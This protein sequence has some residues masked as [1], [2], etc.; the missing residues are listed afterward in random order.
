[1]KVEIL[2][3]GGATGTPS[4]EWGWGRCDPDEPRNRRLRPS[5]LIDGAG[6][7]ILVDTGPD[8]RE[9]LLRSGIQTVD[10]I[11]YTHAHAD[12]LHGI[13]DLRSVNRF[14][15]KALPAYADEETLASIR[16]RFSYVFDPLVDGAT[17]YYK[18]T[19]IPNTL[20][21]GDVV[22][23]GALRM[24]TFAQDH[25][26]ATTMGLRCGPVAYSTD[27]VELTEPAFEVLRGVDTWIVDAFQEPPH[28]THAHVGKVLEW[29]ERIKPRR[30]VLTHMSARLDYQTLRD[31]LP[32][33]VE[34]A[35]DGMILEIP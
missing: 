27:V 14:M 13:D 3:C 9:Q 10:A 16:A 7:R 15:N 21:Y 6:T 29:V 34:P 8:L 24:A 19:L 32:A 12:H 18:P 26:W 33:G 23:I 4:V 20:A 30:T 28:P 35:Y 22:Q 25:G 31:K 5:I 11:V 1:M 17:S 2:G